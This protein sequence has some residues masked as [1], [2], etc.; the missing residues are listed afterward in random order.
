MWG[1]YD[2]E[3]VRTPAGWRVHR[4]IYS[5]ILT[6]GPAVTSRD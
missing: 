6:E 2:D 5:S 4:R 1:L 3:L